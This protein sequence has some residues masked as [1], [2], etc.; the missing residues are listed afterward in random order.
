MALERTVCSLRQVGLPKPTKPTRPVACGREVAGAG[1][2]LVL[3]E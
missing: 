2:E 1:L 3:E